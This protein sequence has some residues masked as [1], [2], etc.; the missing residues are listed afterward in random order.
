M[1]DLQ[2]GDT[3]IDGQTVT[4]ARLNNLVDL[5]TVLA[6]FL[7]G[8]AQVTPVGADVLLLLQTSSGNLKKA[9]ISA[10]PY[11]T[12]AGLVMPSEF[13]VANSPVTGAGTITVTKANKN[14]NL[15]YASPDGS[16]GQPAFRSLVP[17]DINALTVTVAA[18]TID[19][20]LGQAF[21]KQITG[22]FT[23]SFTNTR[24]GQTI[25]LL[26]VQG[27]GGN[28]IWSIG[29][30]NWVGGAIPVFTTTTGHA[31]MFEFT[32]IGTQIYGKPFY[33]FH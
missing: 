1:A 19:W 33:D 5:G 4:G 31:D 7:S 12:S 32:K 6:A 3:F 13:S 27:G 18:S 21:T 11:V 25:R 23:P 28:I 8:K 9:L 22:N 29:A 14:G 30:L 17:K 24:D 15:V 2:K 10:L 26:V 20:S 16:T